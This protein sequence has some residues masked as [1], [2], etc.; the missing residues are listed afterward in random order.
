[1]GLYANYVFP[2]LLDWVMQSPAMAEQRPRVAGAAAG[3]VLEIGFGT[4]LNLPHYTD[5][6]KRLDAIDPASVLRKRVARRIEQSVVPVHTHQ[7]DA[8]RL[9][10][11]DAMFDCVV[12]TWTLCSIDNVQKALGEIRRVLRPGGRFLFVEHGRSDDP[13]VA[14]WQDRLNPL[15]RRVGVG[16]NLNRAIDRLVCDAGFELNRMERFCLRGTP[17]VFGEH[18]LGEASR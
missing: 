16:C 2:H 4:G 3:H 8:A 10:F 1:M 12:S 17:P 18:Y 15:Q 5:A 11:D 7:L 13:R 6:V 9:P 14:R